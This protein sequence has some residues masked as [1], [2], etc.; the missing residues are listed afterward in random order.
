[1]ALSPAPRGSGHGHHNN[2]SSYRLMSASRTWQAW[3]ST[4]RL[5]VDDPVVLGAAAGA[6]KALMDRVDKAASRFRPDSELSAVN[7]RAGSMVPVS[8]LLIDLV[9]VSLV[10]ASMSG[11]AVDPTVG[12]AVLAAGSG[13]PT[14][15]VPGWQQVRLNR[16]VAMVGIPEGTALDL[17]CHSQGL[18]R[19]QSRPSPQ[20]TPRL[21]STGR[22]R[23]RSPSSR[24]SGRTV[25]HPSSRTRRRARRR[26]NPRPRRPDHLHPY[27]AKLVNPRRA[28]P[29]RHRPTHRTPRRRPLADSLGMGADRSKSQHL[30]YCARRHRR[31]SSRPPDSGRTSGTTRCRR[32]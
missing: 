21:R 3:G 31:G 7:T 9:D 25:G 32:W 8:R 18:D 22:N 13:D 19:R 12:A 23:W 26:S 17:G 10:A 24:Y 1:M 30:Q 6:L 28:S 20:Q 16:K 27:C 4:V 11:G 5:T 15:P 2:R 14:S 29:P